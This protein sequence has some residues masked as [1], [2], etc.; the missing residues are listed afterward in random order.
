MLD[1]LDNIFANIAKEA[2]S[3]AGGAISTQRLTSVGGFIFQAQFDPADW[4]GD[5]I[6]YPVTMV[7]TDNIEIGD[8]STAPWTAATVLDA[9][10]PADRKI[11]VGKTVP[12]SSAATEFKWASL[13][14]DAKV[15]LRL[16]PGGDTPDAES[17]GQ[18][19][20]DFVRGV[21][22]NEAPNGTLLRK[23]GRVL[24]DIVN[25]GVAYSGAPSL[26]INDADYVSGF[27]PSFAFLRDRH[28]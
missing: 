12:N 6:P 21:R 17:V 20:L 24:G 26:R 5:L 2:N 18:D 19:R 8:A 15:F 4:S 25:S 9:T 22:T 1:A 28:Q 16:P 11:Y 3:I 27:A 10:D 13:D 7:G 14:D 23:R